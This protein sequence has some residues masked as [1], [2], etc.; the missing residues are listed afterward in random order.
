MMLVIHIYLVG[1]I[2]KYIIGFV[3]IKADWAY[4]VQFVAQE[5]ETQSSKNNLGTMILYSVFLMKQI[6]FAKIRR[7]F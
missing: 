5:Y 6:H 7:M 3:K 1:L 2:G 4:Y